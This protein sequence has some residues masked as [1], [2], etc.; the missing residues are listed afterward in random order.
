MTLFR[1]QPVL[2]VTIGVDLVER[3]RRGLSAVVMSWQHV[4]CDSNSATS[5]IKELY[6]GY[7]VEIV[8]AKRAINSD[9]SKRGAVEE[10]LIRNYGIE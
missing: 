8:H 9:A 6:T 2:L 4:G 1:I 3:S 5:F 7:T 10:V